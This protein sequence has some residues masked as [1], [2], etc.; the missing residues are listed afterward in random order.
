MIKLTAKPLAKSVGSELRSYQKEVDAE[1]DFGRR[2]LLAADRFKQ[3]NRLNNVTFQE[4]KKALTEMCAGARRCMYC[5]DSVADEVEHHHPKN[6]Y[7]EMVFAWSNYLYSCGPCN[8]PKNNRFAVLDPDG[9]LVEVIRPRGAPVVPPPP[10]SPALLHPRADDPVEFITLDI[11]GG[12]FLFV[13]AGKEGTVE[14]VRAKYTIKELR[15]NVRDYL[16]AAR[17]EAYHSY[18]SRLREY[19]AE[20]EAG[21][22]AVVLKRRVDA[23]QRMGHPT[24]WY[25]MRRQQAF[26]PDLATLFRRVPQALQW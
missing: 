9:E 23:L 24:V 18:R 17:R 5:E 2:V 25:E 22:P 15:L 4:I 20:L 10:G 12:T 13:P 16:P 19:A 3:R 14:F 21:E 26:I 1:P 8:G 11:K 6:L 7:P